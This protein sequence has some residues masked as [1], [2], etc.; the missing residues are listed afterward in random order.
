VRRAIDPAALDLLVPNLLLQPLVENAVRHGIA[1]RVAG[2]RIEVSASVSDGA[3][4]IEVTDDGPGADT[5]REG[6]GVSNTRARLEHLYGAAAHL[7]LANVAGGGFRARL[8]LPA[9]TEPLHASPDRR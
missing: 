3:L 9:H 8:Q 5:V 6:V 4:A 7:E 2:G 1:P